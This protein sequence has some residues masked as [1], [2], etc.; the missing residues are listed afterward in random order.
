M[1]AVRLPGVS[2]RAHSQLMFGH[3]DCRGGQHT[4]L[5]SALTPGAQ[6]PPLRSRGLAPQ[7]EVRPM[8]PQFDAIG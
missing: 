4:L 1:T 5:I 6:V 8:S 2:T 7:E 3:R